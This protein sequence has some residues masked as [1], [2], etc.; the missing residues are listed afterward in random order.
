MNNSLRP[1][2]SSPSPQGVNPF[3]RAL[4]EARGA[5]GQSTDSITN[6]G[7]SLAK[8]MNGMDQLDPIEQQRQLEEA[9]KK[10]RLRQQLHK[11]VNPV[12]A[13]DVFSARESQIKKEI[14]QIRHELK[15]LSQE[16]AAFH[17]EI[18]MTLM[19]NVVSPGQEGK[20][21][22]TFFQQLRAF[23]MLLR[24]KIHSAR[25]WATTM[26]G[27]K[28]KKQ[29]KGAGLEISGQQYEQTATVFD[30]MHHERSTVY[31]GS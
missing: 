24:Q 21:Y 11:Q 2:S 18:D 14:D 3:A 5:Q 9:Q 15:L 17:Q 12:E 19:S 22:L 7:N 16:M 20:Y 6:T 27:K 10:E 25:T 28:S 13:K 4:A 1:S 29:R 30:R 23:I 31:S 26:H 8:D